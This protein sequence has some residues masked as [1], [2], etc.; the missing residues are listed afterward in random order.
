VV[1]GFLALASVQTPTHAATDEHC[2]N[3]PDKRVFKFFRHGSLCK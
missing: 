3:E 2:D 1:V